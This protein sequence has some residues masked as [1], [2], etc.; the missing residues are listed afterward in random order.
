MDS[1]LLISKLI[2][3]E[4][5]PVSEINSLL[6]EG[7]EWDVVEGKKFLENPDNVFFLAKWDGEFAGFLTGHRLQR[8]DKRKAEILLY[9]VGVNEKFQKRGIGK[10]LLEMVK[11]WAREVGADE[12]WVLTNKSNIAANALYQSAGGTKEDP[13][14]VTMY[15]FKL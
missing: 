4:D 5:I 6:D 12:V 14:D 13:D 7:V 1:H 8:F 2:Y 15:S 3:S 11:Q 10:A 9:E